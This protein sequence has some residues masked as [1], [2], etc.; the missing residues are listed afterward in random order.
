M[1]EHFAQWYLF[2]V[3][4][5]ANHTLQTL[6][7][8]TRARQLNCRLLVVVGVEDLQREHVLVDLQDVVI[9]VFEVLLPKYL[10]KSRLVRKEVEQRLA[11]ENEIKMLYLTLIQV[12]LLVPRVLPILPQENVHATQWEEKRARLLRAEE[13]LRV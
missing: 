10:N 4:E 6:L 1:Q 2:E 7:G 13:P 11:I 9:D 8:L 3:Q 12:K 5:H